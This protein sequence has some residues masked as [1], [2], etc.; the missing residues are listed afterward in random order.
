MGKAGERERKT[1]RNLSEKRTKPIQKIK[2]AKSQEVSRFASTDFT[3]PK[4][5]VDKERNQ[6]TSLFKRFLTEYK[7]K[8]KDY[9]SRNKL[10]KLQKR[11]FLK[12]SSLVRAKKFEAYEADPNRLI[13]FDEFGEVLDQVDVKEEPKVERRVSNKKFYKNKKI[14]HRWDKK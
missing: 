13:N 6:K 5:K 3:K 1:K 8:E 2:K 7:N 9:I 12:K 10:T 11:R 14:K 4:F